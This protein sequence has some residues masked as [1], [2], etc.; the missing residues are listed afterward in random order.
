MTAM[1]LPLN[2]GPSQC[3]QN[4]TPLFRYSFSPGTFMCRHRAP[5]DTMTERACTVAPL[6][7]STSMRP[8]TSV[9]GVRAL[10]RWRFMMS[11]SYSRTCCSSATASFG[12][13]VYGT[14]MKFSMPMV[15]STWP[16]KRSATTPVLM[17]LRTA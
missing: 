2:S 9:A 5:V 12:P 4:A 11:T 6:S 7:S 13:S 16:P 8:P 14:E 17:P 1:R 3:G 10:A 15:S